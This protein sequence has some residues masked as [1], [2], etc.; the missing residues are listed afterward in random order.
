[1]TEFKKYDEGKPMMSLLDPFFIEKMAKV[2]TMGAKKYDKYN[3]QTC[4]DTDRFKD[5]LYRHLIAYLKGDR[6]DDES[7]LPHL[8]H[9]CVNAMFLDFFDRGQNGTRN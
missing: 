5:A 2:L 9:V 1:M 4:T 3:W 7:G 8:A 6:I